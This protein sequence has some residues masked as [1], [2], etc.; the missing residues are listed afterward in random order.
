M[1]EEQFE[2]LSEIKESVGVD[3]KKTLFRMVYDSW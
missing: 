1:T 3:S 2:E